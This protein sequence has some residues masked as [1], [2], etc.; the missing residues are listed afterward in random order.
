MRFKANLAVCEQ[1]VYGGLAQIEA[2][3]VFTLERHEHHSL[4]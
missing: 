3:T 2:S 1:G 4:Q